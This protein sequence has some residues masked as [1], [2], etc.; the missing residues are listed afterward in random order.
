MSRSEC[1]LLTGGNGVVGSAVLVALCEAG[2]NV[3]AVVRR[4][5]AVDKAS[6]HPLI[7]RFSKQIQWSIVPDISKPDA[8]LEVVKGCSHSELSDNV[9]NPSRKDLFHT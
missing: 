9:L 4:Q 5:G 2:Y 3:H 7:K 6:A 1:V 8:F